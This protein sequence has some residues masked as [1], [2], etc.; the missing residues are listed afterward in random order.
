[1]KLFKNT[2]A[3][4]MILV[5]V[6]V[7]FASLP[8]VNAAS[9][10][11]YIVKYKCP[12][13]QDAS[14]L[15]NSLKSGNDIIYVYPNQQITY[16]STKLGPNNGSAN[17]TW[18]QIKFDYAAREYTGYVAKACMYDVKTYS[19]SDDAAFEESIKDFPDSYK[20]YLRKLH[21]M[22]PNWTFKVNFTNLDWETAAEAES[23]KGTSA[24]SHLYPSLIFKDETNPNGI[25][26][27]GTSWYA[28]AKDAV[29]YYMDPRNFLNEKGIFMFENLSYDSR[30]DSSVAG[31]LEG[32]F[33]SGS[34]TEDGYTKTYAQAF[35]DAG[36]SSGVSSIHLASRA[37]QEVGTTMSSAVSGTVQGYEGYYNFYNIGAY[38]GED[39]YLKGLEYAKNNDWSSRQKAITGG[40]NVIGQNYI[41]KGQ[42]TLYFQ[43]FNV[44]SYRVYNTYTH[45]YMTNIMAASKE[46]ASIY[47]SY[48][49]NNKL[50]SNYTFII[51]VYNNM[52][53]SAF[54]VSTT[55]TVGGNDTDKDKEEEKP[56]ENVISPEEKIAK[57]GYLLST[58]YLTKVDYNSDI[59]TLR[60]RITNQKANVGSMDSNWVSKTSGVVATGDLVSV[61][62]KVFQVVVYGDVSGDGVISIKDLL[63]VQKYLLKSQDIT[64][65]NLTAADVSK[66]GAVTIKDLLLI[67][68]Y[69]LGSGSI[70]Q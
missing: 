31:V 38:S 50:S 14:D 6:F 20:P 40:A 19:Y 16:I 51:P 45:Q 68:K 41:K 2:F 57:A 29:K 58:G 56:I 59:S 28:P 18:Y 39:N 5:I 60:S 25:V 69:L 15:S 54:K 64:G 22:Y 48:K 65:C 13:R 1:M 62:E 11:A 36:S 42:D 49:K 61:D 46:A 34:F 26:V 32:S 21:A 43:K 35:I 7:S 52:P 24:I 17:Q 12:V 33:M 9:Y 47:E 44:S 67:Q 3:F 53:S 27:D 8:R 37:L 4:F 10:D 70:E 30:A 55:D 63:L 66:D 23:Q